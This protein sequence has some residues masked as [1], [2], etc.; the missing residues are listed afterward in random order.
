[1]IVISSDSAIDVKVPGSTLTNSGK[2]IAIRSASSVAVK[3]TTPASTTIGGQNDRDLNPG[4]WLE[5]VS[6]GANKNWSIAS[7]A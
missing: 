2:L 4:A 3:L 6:D 7:S 5:L 1:M